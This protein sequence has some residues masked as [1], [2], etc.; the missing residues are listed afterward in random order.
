MTECKHEKVN[1]CGVTADIEWCEDC[2][3]LR[4]AR[5]VTDWTEWQAPANL[6]KTHLLEGSVSTL[7]LD[8]ERL[9]VKIKS[10]A[11]QPFDIGD[12]VETQYDDDDKPRTVTIHDIKSD[13]L[14]SSGWRVW[15][16]NLPGIC[17]AWFKK[18]PV[19][20]GDD[21]GKNDPDCPGCT[22]GKGCDGCKIRATLNTATRLMEGVVAQNGGLYALY[23]EGKELVNS[24]QVLLGKGAT[25]VFGA[26]DRITG[27]EKT[28]K[29]LSARNHELRV[30]R[31][32]LKTKFSRATA[33]IFDLSQQVAKLKKDLEVAKSEEIHDETDRERVVNKLQK[34]T[35]ER[36]SRIQELESGIVKYK[37]AI[38]NYKESVNNLNECNCITQKRIQE[39]EKAI[40]TEPW[41]AALKIEALEKENALLRKEPK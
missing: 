12:V 5:N 35:I 24:A 2:G 33:M 31:D 7:E 8:N 4:S 32:G 41:Q 11:V 18:P 30:E 13:I 26:A 16:G 10:M 1:V 19:E 14:C 40:T 3:S 28:I 25:E 27:M 20:S 38:E 37:S 39:L 6:D 22:E 23:R 9:R 15:A 36:L 17:S 29:E 34:L 21:S